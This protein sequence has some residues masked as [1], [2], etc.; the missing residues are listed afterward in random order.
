MVRDLPATA[1]LQDLRAVPE[2]TALVVNLTG[3]ERAAAALCE[4]GRLERMLRRAV[5][6]GDELM[7]KVWACVLVRCW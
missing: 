5:A 2:L 4:G 1:A 3:C 6:S 7:F